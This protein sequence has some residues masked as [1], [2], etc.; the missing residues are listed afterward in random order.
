MCCRSLGACSVDALCAAIDQ[1]VADDDAFITLSTIHQANALEAERVCVLEA[2]TPLRQ[3]K[4]QCPGQFP[5]VLHLRDGTL[6]HAKQDLVLLLAPDTT[7]WNDVWATAFGTAG[8]VARNRPRGPP[9]QRLSL[10]LGQT[11]K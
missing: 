6:T 8:W 11:Y 2:N 7:A 5:Q 10:D 1:H 4:P 9:A 3:W